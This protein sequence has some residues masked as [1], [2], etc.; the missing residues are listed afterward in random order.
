MET[1][2]NYPDLASAQVVSALLAGEGIEVSIPDE[3]YVGLDWSMITALQGVRLQVVPDDATRAKELLVQA[4]EDGE[5]DVP[6]SEP[7]LGVDVC[8][9]CQS[10]SIAPSRWRTRLKAA[11]ILIPTL[12]LVWPFVMAFR[13]RMKCSACGLRW[14]EAGSTAPPN[15]R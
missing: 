12:W 6:E 10:A 15:P 3:Q 1:I 11:T 2:G 9:R 14:R 7:V 13:P 5:P 8:P 4:S